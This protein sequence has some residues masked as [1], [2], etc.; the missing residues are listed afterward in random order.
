[1]L[2]SKLLPPSRKQLIQKIIVDLVRNLAT[3]RII[4]H[5]F[6]FPLIRL[7]AFLKPE[8][9]MKHTGDRDKQMIESLPREWFTRYTSFQANMGMKLLSQVEQSDHQRIDNVSLIK[10]ISTKI[11][12]PSGVEGAENVYWQLVAYFDDPRA[13]QKY[14]H[15]NKIDTSTTSLE[16]I[17]SLPEYP[18][19]GNTP[20]ADKL[21]ANGLFVPSYPSL[22]KSDLEHIGNVLNEMERV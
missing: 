11:N 9:A 10:S 20:N 8:S 21:Y 18:F 19:Q 12:F 1:M 16:K 6:V 22:K 13:T 2:Q 4:F 14:L 17:S 7:M 15:S 3:T 5:I